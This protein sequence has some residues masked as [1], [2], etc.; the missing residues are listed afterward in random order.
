MKENTREIKFRGL[1][2]NNE[3]HYGSVILCNE[4]ISSTIINDTREAQVSTNSISQYTGLK[5]KNGVDIYEGDIV[6]WKVK[7]RGEILSQIEILKFKNGSFILECP[8]YNCEES[9][10]EDTESL[11][12]ESSVIGNI[13]QNKG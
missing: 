12:E 3:W 6:E 4:D 2:L 7:D 11:T 5:D 10:Y 9:V 1:D 13:Y 8:K